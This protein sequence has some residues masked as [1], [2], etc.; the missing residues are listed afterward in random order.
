MKLTG[1]LALSQLKINRSRTAWTL[2]GIV[3][4]TA[5][6]TAVCSFEA[7]GNALILDL[8]GE[9]YG[10][11]AE[12]LAAL[13]L[14]PA[15]IIVAIIIAMS[16]VAISNA[17]RASAGERTAQFGM[18]KSV[19]AT[20]QQIIS[21][22]MYESAFLSAAGIPI[23]LAIGLILAFAGV[24]IANYFFGE[25]NSLIHMMLN[26]ITIALDFVIAWQALIAAAFISF[27]AVLLSAWL[28]ARK[29]AKITAIASIR[30]T[31]EVEIKRGSVK[32]SRLT[33]KIFGLEGALAAK[34]MKRSKRNFRASVASLTVSVILFI[35][36][37]SLSEQARMVEN[38]LMPDIDATVIVDYTSLRDS[39]V[40]E[41]TGR[42]ETVV[43]APIDS[44]VAN[45]IA[46]RLREYKGTVIM[47][48][49]DDME[50]YISIVP[51]EAISSQMLEA[52]FNDEERDEREVSTEILTL[53][54]ESYAA[55]CERAGV[56]LGSN[57]L[58]NHYSYIDNGAEVAF[59]PFLLEGENIRLVKADGS[60]S[61]LTVHGALTQED[62]PNELFPFNTQTVRLI[63]PQGQMRN[64]IW[65]ANPADID[66]F[67]EYANAVMDEIFP[68]GSEA[69]YMELGFSTR[70]YTLQDYMKVMNIPIGLAM[71][72]IYSF[73]ALLSLIGLTDVISTISANVRMRSR[74]F[75]VLRSVGMT[76]GGIK[77][78]LNFE[79]VI[80]TANS[81]I[82]GLPL[83][84][85][86]TYLINLPIRSTF[87]IPYQFPW[88]ACACCIFAVFAVTWVAMRHCASWLRC[89]GVIGAILTEG[90]I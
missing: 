66:G 35:T 74:E 49:G 65:Y 30:G 5:L 85:A 71:V 24:Q 62:V 57:I 6:I 10:G 42:T 45:A 90:G 27:A 26:E 55:L 4:S 40:N 76:Y 72:F 67:K 32:T 15:G 25:L 48:A 2:T 58:I 77:R 22:V 70:V 28:P 54:L 8:F 64:Y 50:T 81:L 83:A 79:S 34:N 53:D 75:A 68:R 73:V 17:F 19:G 39:F 1:K 44:E 36:L 31:D 61:E 88:L 3:L 86:L 12:T 16:V 69:G 38:L 87:P 43:S 41:S 29:A 11:S 78:M 46:E 9:G 47:G 59:T 82:I 20:K 7:S 51:N 33:Q 63:V 18:L 56:P 52:Y 80:C 13:L 89:E 37:S 23:G 84:V 14:I 60:A 21:S